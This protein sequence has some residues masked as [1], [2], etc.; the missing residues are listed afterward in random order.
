MSSRNSM[1]LRP[2]PHPALF[3]LGTRSR[4]WDQILALSLTLLVLSFRARE[5][6]STPAR[7]AFPR[8]LRQWTHVSF[9][10]FTCALCT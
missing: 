2:A 7:P 5:R 1:T 9:C 4:A 10:F 3:A 6:Q 8:G